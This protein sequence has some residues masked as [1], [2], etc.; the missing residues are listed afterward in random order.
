MQHRASSQR[1][2][3]LV[4]LMVVIA[5]IGILAALTLP[6]FNNATQEAK[7]EAARSDGN[8][9]VKAMKVFETQ[10]DALP[11]LD[12]WYTAST[13]TNVETCWMPDPGESDPPYFDWAHWCRYPGGAFI[14]CPP[15]QP[16]EVDP[17]L[18]LTPRPLAWY[19]RASI[20]DLDGYDLVLSSQLGVQVLD[21]DV[22]YEEEPAVAGYGETLPGN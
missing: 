22:A 10:H 19:A 7:K 2:F 3:T 13:V 4:E 11:L 9:M 5:I 17:Q 14:P 16:L 8:C 12:G 18:M 21:S 1:G 6:H 20:R 15:A